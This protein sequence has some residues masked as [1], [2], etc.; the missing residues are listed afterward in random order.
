MTAELDSMLSYSLAAKAM[1][2]RGIVTG[3]Y[4]PEENEEID[5]ML[6]WAVTRPLPSLSPSRPRA[7][8]SEKSIGQG[9]VASELVLAD[10]VPERDV[11]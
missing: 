9:S 1:R 4:M 6:L 11:A 2:L 3:E 10:G 7:T 5:L 8:S